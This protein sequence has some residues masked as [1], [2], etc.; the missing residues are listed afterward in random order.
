[1]NISWKTFHGVA[2]S[3]LTCSVLALGGPALAQDAPKLVGSVVDIDG[4]VLMTNRLKEAKW[5]QAYPQM[6]TYLKERM[7]ADEKTTATIEFLVG[8][9]AVISPG[10]EV[11]IVTPKDTTVLKIKSGTV[12]AK[13]DKQDKQF[14]IETSGGVMGIEG[15]EFIVTT[16]PVTGQTK[17]V[18]VEGSVRVNNELV[19]GGKE[20]DFGKSALKVAEFAAYNTPESAIRE[21]AFGKLDPQTRDVLMPVVNRALWALPGQY[22]IGRYFYSREFGYARRALRLLQDPEA[23]ITD[24]VASQ[25]GSRVGF[26]VGGMLRNANKPPEPVKDIAAAGATPKF[27]W[28][29]VKGAS[30]YT[31]VVANDSEAKE[32]VWYG[33]ADGKK[34]QLDYPAYGPELASGKTYYLFVMPLNNKGEPHTHKDKNLG[35]NTTFAG[36]GHTPQYGNVNGLTAAAAAGT[37]DATWSPVTGATTYRVLI[38]DGAKATVWSEESKETRYK[39]PETARALDPGDYS[40]VVE[41]FDASGLKMAQSAPATFASSGWDAVGLTGP[42]RPVE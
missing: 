1:M 12:W 35:G 3:A 7:K 17:L 39:Y 25:V 19:E 9:R 24:E 33:V 20:A 23:A 26:G 13:F 6:K 41:A 15:T 2:V 42:E 11:E 29:G 30:K 16:D 8:G 14:Q 38:Q 27:T 5:Y 40:V 10:T 34:T 18:V 31:V 4:P 21:A 28:D 32:V 36:T 37:P 22:R